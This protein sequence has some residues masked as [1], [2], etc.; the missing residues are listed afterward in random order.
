LKSVWQESDNG[1]V[2]ITSSITYLSNEIQGCSINTVQVDFEAEDQT[3]AQYGWRKWG[4]NVM[5]RHFANI[6][7]HIKLSQMFKNADLDRLS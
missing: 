5:V 3:A 1:V 7:S 4:E 6:L 2:N